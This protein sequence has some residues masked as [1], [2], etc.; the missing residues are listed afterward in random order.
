[1]KCVTFILVLPSISIDTP[2]IFRKYT[3]NV[4]LNILAFKFHN[5]MSRQKQS[6]LKYAKMLIEI[7]AKDWKQNAFDVKRP[8]E[9][10]YDYL[11]F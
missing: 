3:L 2:Y 6:W 7:L 1:M 10:I 5:S 9:Q 4:M 8:I 11:K